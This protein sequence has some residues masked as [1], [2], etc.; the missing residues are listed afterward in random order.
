MCSCKRL[1][2]KAPLW[3]PSC[4][5]TSHRTPLTLGRA[6]SQTIGSV[7]GVIAQ[8]LHCHLG[9][10]RSHSGHFR[11]LSMKNIGKLAVLGAVLAASASFGFADT[12]TL[13]SYG[14]AG[15]SGYAP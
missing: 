7:C 6:I 11:R 13:G 5:I 4:N 10:T 2:L 9:P 15:L 12:I 8:M 1:I 3:S 14:S